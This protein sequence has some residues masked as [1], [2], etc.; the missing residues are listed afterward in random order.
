MSL[1]IAGERSGV[2]KTT[3]TLAMLA[4]LQRRGLQ[5]QSFKVGPDYIDPMFHQY[6]TRRASRN[7]DPV[8]TSEAYVQQCFTRHTQSVDYALVEG[9]MGLF[10]GVKETG[11]WGLV[12]GD[13]NFELNLDNDGAKN[14]INSQSPINNYQLLT[15]FASTAHIARLLSLPVVLVIDCSRLSGSVAAIAHGYRSFDPRLKIAGVVLNRVGSDRHLELLQDALEPLQLPI[16]GILRRQD[17][18][19]IPDRH[20]GL[21]PTGEIA[22]LDSLIDKLAYLGETCFNWELLLPLLKVETNSP[23][24]K[25][26]S[27]DLAPPLD[28]GRSWGGVNPH[29]DDRI[30][31]PPR[32]SGRSWGGIRIAV[33]RDRAFNFYYQDNLDQLQLGAELIFWS[34]LTDTELPENVQGMYFGGGFPEVFAQELSDNTSAKDAVKKA[35]LAGMPTYAECGGLMY[36]CEDIVNFDQQSYPM[37]GVLPTTA[38]MSSRLSLGYRMAIALQDSPLLPKSATVRGHEFHRSE[39]SKIPTQPLYNLRSYSAHTSA[40]IE[41]WSLHQLHASYVHLHFGANAEIPLRFW[42]HCHQWQFTT[43]T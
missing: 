22:E 31:L 35:I 19:N 4:C 34:P 41:G 18:I 39:L 26:K 38:V 6:V 20:L 7:L 43:I 32:N 8:L 29:N 3:I 37:V 23:Q 14:H 33:A 40:K 11:D 28:K 12:T 36:L 15:D 21:V 5:V 10:D 25:G 1:V 13:N 2:G 42:Q 16:L 9:V 30:L 17:N 27:P 24:N